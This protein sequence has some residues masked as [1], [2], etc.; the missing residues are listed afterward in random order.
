MSDAPSAWVARLL[1]RTPSPPPPSSSLHNRS[2]PLSSLFP[3]PSPLHSPPSL[4]HAKRTRFS[5]ASSPPLIPRKR[6]SPPSSED[7]RKEGEP[8]RE[9]H[10]AWPP[11]GEPESKQSSNEVSN[12]YAD[13][14]RAFPSLS[15]GHSW[16]E[17]AEGEEEGKEERK[18]GTGQAAQGER[19]GEGESMIDLTDEDEAIIVPSH[20]RSSAPPSSAPP[21]FS[22]TVPFY[23]PYTSSPASQLSLHPSLEPISSS[24]PSSFSSSASSSSPSPSPS[25]Y[26]TT[27]ARPPSYNPVYQPRSF[28]APRPSAADGF[29]DLTDDVEDDAIEP[30]PSKDAAVPPPSSS[31]PLSVPSSVKTEIDL[32][33][34]DGED[35]L[36]VK[37]G[38]LIGYVKHPNPLVPLRPSQPLSLY[39]APS[40]EEQTRLRVMTDDEE[41]VGVL[42][43]EASLPIAPLLLDRKLNVEV[44][45]YTV[46]P[47]RAA[48]KIALFGTEGLKEEV[49]FKVKTHNPNDYWDVSVHEKYWSRF[50]L[51]GSSVPPSRP[52]SSTGPPQW[53]PFQPSS[54]PYVS[55]PLAPSIADVESHLDAL[56]D[57]E[58]H[59][60]GYDIDITGL[61]VP[62]C[63][64]TPMHEYQLQGLAWMTQR[65]QQTVAWK[66]AAKKAVKK[67]PFTGRLREDEDTV[68]TFLSWE[69]RTDRSGRTT[70]WNRSK[71]QAK[72]QAREPEFVRGGILADD[73]GLGKTLQM[74]AVIAAGKERGEEGPTLIVCPLSVITNWQQQIEQ[75]VREAYRWR[76]YTYHGNTRVK[77]SEVLEQCDVVITTYNIVSSEWVAEDDS[78]KKDKAEQKERE[79][80][81]RAQGTVVVSRRKKEETE[82]DE[83]P[84]D[85]A[86]SLAAMHSPLFWIKWTRV[87]LD[88]GHNIRERRTRQSRACRALA[89]HC[90]WVMTGTP[91]QN[92]LDDG[93]ALM[94]FLRIEPFTSHLWWTKLILQ[95]IKDRNPHGVERLQRIMSSI[96]IRRRKTDELNGRRILTLPDKTT[97]YIEV[98]LEGEEKHLYTLLEVSAKKEFSALLHQG[99]VL[100]HFARL[101]E[102]LLRLRQ[103]CDHSTLVPSHYYR[104]GFGLERGRLDDT[105]RLLTLLAESSNDTCTLCHRSIDEEEASIVPCCAEIFHSDCLSRVFTTQV[106]VPGL[107]FAPPAGSAVVSCPS[108]AQQL[109]Q[110]RVVTNEMKDLISAEDARLALTSAQPTQSQSLSSVA[111]VARH[112]PKMRV[113]LQELQSCTAAGDKAVVFSQWTSFLD[114]LEPALDA[115]NIR[116]V[117]LDGSMPSAH[118]A[119]ALRA[120]H[121][122][123]DLHVFLISLKAGGV[124]LNL[125]AANRVYLLDIWWNPA[126][127]DQAVDR[128]HRLGQTKAVDVVKLIVRDTVEERVLKLQIKKREMTGLAMAGVERTR[129]EEQ[130]ERLNDLKTLFG[131]T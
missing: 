87:V 69:R 115:A 97:R 1:D 52:L 92:R 80:E 3:S 78:E 44:K 27:S 68:D 84:T 62:A 123:A 117:R 107:G 40:V 104:N 121:A 81:Q 50:A 42:N 108:C 47:E 89:A 2:P 35:Q 33:D 12:D 7:E 124:G 102:M 37:Y 49:A 30:P 38:T 71:P 130:Q 4:P 118:R 129:A 14:H 93:Y 96:C 34:D 128:V 125:T 18:S 8:D 28:D 13:D 54:Q 64:G 75:H 20:L 57:S 72:P 22:S 6:L 31:R 110:D 88:E 46:T 58:D 74:I 10:K 73:M 45:V 76:V 95:P 70:Y 43:R 23:A 15:S 25:S 26:P 9:E 86:R 126:A 60:A 36:E 65:E 109:R 55:T 21:P 61:T 39:L 85:E 98:P 106:A 101:L 41:E 17:R 11:A 51:T 29:V 19:Q 91:F 66:P 94:H 67:D 77:E 24:F 53:P 131:F 82:A 16:R 116:H 103:C 59:S 127:E 5:P 122:N 63:I 114:L 79:K 56:F 100:S 120:F 99:E 32:V 111:S 48:L 83:F 90:R 113:L 119:N 112:S 105:R